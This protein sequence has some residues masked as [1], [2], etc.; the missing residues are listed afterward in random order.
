MYHDVAS[1]EC[2]PCILH[3]HGTSTHVLALHAYIFVCTLKCGA[4]GDY[5]FRNARFC[6]KINWLMPTHEEHIPHW[7]LGSVVIV[8][9][10]TFMISIPGQF[11]CEWVKA[12]VL[13]WARTMGVATLA[14][15]GTLF[16]MLM[17]RA[18][19]IQS[20][21]SQFFANLDWLVTLIIQ[22]ADAWT[23]RFG[24]FCGDNDRQN[25]LLYH[26]CMRAE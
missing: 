18:W 21:L 5:I 19:L 3:L 22:D 24:D 10:I 6:W 8:V 23:L 26:L 4:H 2:Y 1:Y 9:Q 20:T 13:Q 11:V 16:V 12:N 15:R 17:S 25:Q 7:H 14:N